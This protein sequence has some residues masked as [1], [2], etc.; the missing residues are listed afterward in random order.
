MTN[1]ELAIMGLIAEGAKHGYQIE[2]II[3]KRGMRNWTEIG[4]SSIYYLLKKLEKKGFV[5]SALQETTRGPVRKIYRITEKG[6]STLKE[7]V[8]KALSEPQRCTLPIQAGLYRM[9]AAPAWPG[10]AEPGFR[11]VGGRLEKGNNHKGNDLHA[12]YQS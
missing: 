5:K 2:Q 8:V 1:A 11:P 6:E 10:E 12:L 7:E 9:W 4:F 3:K